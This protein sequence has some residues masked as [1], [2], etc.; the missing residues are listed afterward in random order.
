MHSGDYIAQISGQAGHFRC[1]RDVTCDYR[2]SS[3]LA[4]VLQPGPSTSQLSQA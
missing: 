3:L 1:P 4:M 2:D